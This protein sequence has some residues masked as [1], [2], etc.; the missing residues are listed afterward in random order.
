MD[1]SPAELLRA[2]AAGDQQAWNRIV[3]DYHRLVWS[4][5]RGFR[6]S[7]ADAADVSQTTWLRLVENLD[8]IRDP[9]QLAGWLATTARRE[10]LRLIRQ[11]HREIPD[12]GGMAAAAAEGPDPGGFFEGADSGDPEAVVV[13]DEERTDL[14]AAFST[15]T[16]KCRNLLRVVAV[17]PLASYNAV[18]EALGMPVGSIGPTRSRCLEQL[19]R[20]LRHLHTVPETTG[21]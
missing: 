9:E 21:S 5:A 19:K 14:W 2:A 8:R 4:V 20:A 18:A 3:D 17:T 10:S 16:D 12:G 1:R 6:L 11:S 7:Q 15:L 13:A